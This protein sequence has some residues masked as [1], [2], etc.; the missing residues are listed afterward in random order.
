VGI[1]AKAL[2]ELDPQ[3]T[4]DRVRYPPLV[5]DQQQQIALLGTEAPVELR[6]LALG[7]ELGGRRAPAVAL[8]ERPNQPLGAQ[9][10]GAGDQAVQLGA[11]QLATTG[12]EPTHGARPPRSP[13]GRP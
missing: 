3:L 11:G 9:L 12:V 8:A 5:G 4:E 2:G 13:H 1:S 6:Q 10:L 7:E